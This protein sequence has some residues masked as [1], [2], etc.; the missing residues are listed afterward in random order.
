MLTNPAVLAVL[1]PLTGAK[2]IGLAAGL[3]LRFRQGERFEFSTTNYFVNGLDL[4]ATGVSGPANSGPGNPMTVNV[5]WFNQG[6]SAP[7][8]KA[9]SKSG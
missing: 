8:A 3:P 6:T 4:V 5:K 2:V 7:P 1:M 9:F